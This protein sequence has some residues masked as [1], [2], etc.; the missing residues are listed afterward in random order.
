MIIAQ[1]VLNFLYFVI[2]KDIMTSFLLP[3]F[4][5]PFF[6]RFVVFYIS[7]ILMFSFWCSAPS[8]GSFIFI[9][10]YKFYY[11]INH[12]IFIWDF[13]FVINFIV[14]SILVGTYILVRIIKSRFRNECLNYFSIIIR[15]SFSFPFYCLKMCW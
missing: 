10:F 1:I 7:S 5:L 15:K 3:I 9:S 4:Y 12:H 11:H 2:Q 13:G 14:T 6:N 8:L